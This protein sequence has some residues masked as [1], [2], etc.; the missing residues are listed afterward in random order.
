MRKLKPRKLLMGILA[1]FV[2]LMIVP[3]LLYLLPPSDRRLPDR[4]SGKI[5]AY[6]SELDQDADGIDDQTDI[7]QSAW[8]Y[9]ATRPEYKSR[10]YDGGYPD[11]GYGVCTDVVA[12]A[13]KGAGYDLS[14][15][16]DHD[17]RTN[18]DDYNVETP[19]ANIDFRRVRNLIVYFQH[20]A[21]SLT[22]DPN[23]TSE[24]QGG[25]IVIFKEHIGIVSDRRNRFGVP[26]LIHH[27]GPFQ[28]YYEEDVLSMRT[29]ILGHY[30]VIG[31]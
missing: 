4:Y 14:A 6:V 7:L 2:L 3:V 18:Y 23:E 29:D 30:R 13:L 19:D 26:Y 25:D 16:V 10:Y 9:L 27:Y 17:I 5:P 24:W 20:H 11:D 31:E 8:E 15:L 21:L 1:V 28:R 22:T 12:F